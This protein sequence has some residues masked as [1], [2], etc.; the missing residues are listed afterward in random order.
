[1]PRSHTR[2]SQASLSPCFLPSLF[3]HGQQI[4]RTMYITGSCVAVYV[5][6]GNAPA[7]HHTAQGQC[8]R[9]RFCTRLSFLWRP[10]NLD[11]HMPRPCICNRQRLAECCFIR[12]AECCFICRSASPTPPLP[13]ESS[14]H[15]C[16][17]SLHALSQSAFLS[18]TTGAFRRTYIYTGIVASPCTSPRQRTG[19]PPHSN[20]SVRKC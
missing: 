19:A 2:I 6:T 10:C 4:S 16:M 15:M 1:M 12:R 9:G 8:G 7:H 3:S 5:T 11:M 17:T 20:E 14:A 18:H 13:I